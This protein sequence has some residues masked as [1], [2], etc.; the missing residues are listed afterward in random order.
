MYSRR[1]IFLII[2]FLLASIF[3]TGCETQPTGL[4]IQISDIQG[5]I[6]GS[7]ILAGTQLQ[8]YVEASGVGK[9]TFIWADSSSGVLQ[10]GDNSILNYTV[11]NTSG[12]EV[13][14]VTVRS[15]NGGEKIKSI[16][17]IVIQP[18]VTPY[19]TPPMTLTPRF[20]SE[21]STPFIT[22]TIIPTPT[23]Q[24]YTYTTVNQDTLVGI[25]IRFLS[26]ADY[27]NAIGLANCINIKTLKAGQK[28]IIEVY[29]VQFGDALITIAQKFG[30]GIDAIRSVNN[31]KGDTIYAGQILI[32]PVVEQCK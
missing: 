19:A 23:P 8:V 1:F 14:Q 30:V 26:T 2:A 25:S 7:Q 15:S 13:L 22:A 5:L 16:S 32:M 3:A 9:L 27:A 21:I 28:L 12:K 29:T 4:I 18:A 6:P 10:S 17:Y 11:P 24:I 20:A 31:L